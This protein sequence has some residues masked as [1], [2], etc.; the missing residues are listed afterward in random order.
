[1]KLSRRFPSAIARAIFYFAFSFLGNKRSAASAHFRWEMTVWSGEKLI[2]FWQ[3]QWQSVTDFNGQLRI[4]RNIKKLI[5]TGFFRC[6]RA[7]FVGAGKGNRTLLSSLGSLHSTDEL[8]LQYKTHG[9]KA[10]RWSWWADLNRW[11]ADYEST[12]LNSPFDTLNIGLYNVFFGR[13][14]PKR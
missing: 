12:G 5:N 8:Y 9:S 11:P 3:L 6:L 2:T 4:V 10:V 7:F 13:H 1:M 14:W